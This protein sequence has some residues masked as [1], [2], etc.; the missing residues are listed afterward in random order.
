VTD[1]KTAPQYQLV[2]NDL[3]RQILEGVLPPGSILPSESELSKTYGLSRT[4]VRSAIREL[5]NAG[6]IDVSHGRGAFVRIPR[7]KVRREAIDRYRWEKEQAALSLDQR[8][9]SSVVERD[10][11][12]QHVDVDESAV[13]DSVPANAD[14][15]TRFQVPPGIK[16]LRRRYEHRPHL[17]QAPL[18]LITSYQPWAQAERNPDL[19]DAS[20]EPWPGGTIHQ[21]STIGI[22]VMKFI[23]EI[24]ARP[25]TIDE[26]EMLGLSDG[27]AVFV[28][29]KV[30]LDADGQVVDITDAVL[31][32][33]RTE[34]VYE[35]DLPAWPKKPTKKR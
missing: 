35:I 18:S 3:S 20:N 12:L 19:L 23:D 2:A 13:F 27:T 16:L 7:A 25:P 30:A 28:I 5:A 17:E 21:L 31:P 1:R 22:E 9:V 34:L 4:S 14:L 11:G 8:R 6:M 15:A 29:R 33:D 24:T 10:S 32:G 26:A